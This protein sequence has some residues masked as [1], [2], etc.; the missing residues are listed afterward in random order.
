MEEFVREIIAEFRL[1]VFRETLRHL[2]V[3]TR[4]GVLAR[5][6]QLEALGAGTTCRTDR[7]GADGAEHQAF[8][9][10]H[11]V[12]LL[13]CKRTSGAACARV[14]LTARSA[15]AGRNSC[16]V[17][18]I[19]IELDTE[20]GRVGHVETPFHDLRHGLEERSFHLLDPEMALRERSVPE[21]RHMVEAEECRRR[22]RR[23]GDGCR[24]WARCATRRVSVMPPL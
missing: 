21:A 19:A 5:N 15:L 6:P 10:S 12:F 17:D 2:K 20:T 8:H 3:E 22:P 11:I 7:K 13:C 23:T 14:G 16:L 24:I 9:E 18:H 1:E 4:L